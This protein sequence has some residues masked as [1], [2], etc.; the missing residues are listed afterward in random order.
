MPRYYFHFSDGTH[1]F[2]DNTG[3][4]LVGLRAVRAHAIK[5]VRALTAALCERHVQDL[6]GWTMTVVNAEGKAVFALG[7]DLKPRLVPIEFAPE[8][9]QRELHAESAPPERAT[10]AQRLWT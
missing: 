6:S 3:H 5:D 7:F 9:R 4:E 1:W 8:E 2:S 10:L